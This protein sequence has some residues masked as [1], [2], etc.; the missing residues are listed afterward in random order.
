L[1]AH[2][3]SILDF[4]DDAILA[5]EK[6]FYRLMEAISNLK[7]IETSTT[8]TVD[9]ATWKQSCYNAMNDDFNSPILIANL[10]EGVRIINLLKENKES[11]STEDLADL[12]ATMHAFAFDVL[13][14]ENADQN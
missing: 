9:I 7:N 11:I 12:E 6:G 10:F 14:L 13:G 3:R 5:S 8:S 2:Y 1:Q 4:S